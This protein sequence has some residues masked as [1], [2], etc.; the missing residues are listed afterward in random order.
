V[1]AS[2]RRGVR[3]FAGVFAEQGKRGLEMPIRAVSLGGAQC[4]PDAPAFVRFGKQAYGCRH[5]RGRALIRG[6]SDHEGFVQD[7]GACLRAEAARLEHG[8]GLSLRYLVAVLKRLR[9]HAK[10]VCA[11]RKLRSNG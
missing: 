9:Q 5:R 2:C 8:D 6:C 10:V 11:P 7:L 4:A 3:A 1:N